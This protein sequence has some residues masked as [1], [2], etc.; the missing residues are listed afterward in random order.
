MTISVFRSRL[1]S[2]GQCPFST[3]SSVAGSRCRLNHPICKNH[4]FGIVNFQLH[5]K[6][7]RSIFDAVAEV[8][9]SGRLRKV[10]P[11]VVG[12]V[13]IKEEGGGLEHDGACAFRL[14]FS[15]KCL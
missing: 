6:A 11:R 10:D 15:N 5:E 7:M 8:G 3:L 12:M 14:N 9:D 2:G 1:S 13:R 4:S